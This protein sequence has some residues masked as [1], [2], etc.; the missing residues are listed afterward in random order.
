MSATKNRMECIVR[1]RV[2]L[3]M[4]RDFTKRSADNFGIVG[5][6][7][8]TDNGTV[9]VVA[10]GEE[11]NLVLFLKQLEKGS[12]LSRVDSIDTHPKEPTGEFFDFTIVYG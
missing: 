11:A 8:N 10:E 9:S 2:Q 5:E 4:F 12:L 6:V 3:V 1:G 7:R